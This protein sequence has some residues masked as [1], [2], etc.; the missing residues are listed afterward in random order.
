ML[1]DLCSPKSTHDETSSRH[2][3]CVYKAV[4]VECLPPTL[5]DEGNALALVRVFTV[6][7]QTSGS[8]LA[9]GTD[10]LCS[11]SVSSRRKDPAQMILVETKPAKL[12]R[13]Q[14]VLLTME[15]VDPTTRSELHT[16][17]KRVEAM[18]GCGI[19]RSK[20]VRTCESRHLL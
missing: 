18:L 17:S 6:A 4:R 8:S 10:C 12:F 5:V 15:V 7:S 16:H 2:W 3:L 9:P 11:V 20:G 1:F 19:G 13:V 14:R